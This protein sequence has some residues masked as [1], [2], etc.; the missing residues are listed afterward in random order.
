MH[1]RSANQA[2]TNKIQENNRDRKSQYA[3]KEGARAHGQLGIRPDTMG[4]VCS[5]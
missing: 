1:R 5:G 3:K 4:D 2:T